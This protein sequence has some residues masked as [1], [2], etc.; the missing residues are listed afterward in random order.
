M[1]NVDELRS[2]S[3]PH[4]PINNNVLLNSVGHHSVL[5]GQRD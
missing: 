2:L 5:L 3:F 1:E 4:G